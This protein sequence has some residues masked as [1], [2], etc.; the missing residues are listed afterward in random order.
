MILFAFLLVPLTALGLS[1][2]RATMLFWPTMVIMGAVHSHIPAVPPLGA[3]ATWLV[4][5]L[6]S[7][8]IPTASGGD[9]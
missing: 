3:T 6:I 2:L 4:V 1:I 7:L 8:L 9:S 5:A